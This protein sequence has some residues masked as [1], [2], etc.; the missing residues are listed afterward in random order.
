MSRS[1]HRRQRELVL[2]AMLLAETRVDRHEV[3]RKREQRR[4]KRAA[5]TMPTVNERRL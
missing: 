4:A 3:D 5:W 2:Q 1:E